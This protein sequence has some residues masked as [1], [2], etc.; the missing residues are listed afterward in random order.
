MALTDLQKV[1]NKAAQKVRDRAYNQRLREQRAALN[2]VDQDPEVIRLRQLADEANAK[3]E[4]RRKSVIA[5]RDEI[6]EQIEALQA[7]LA[8]LNYDAKLGA[9]AEARRDASNWW[10][11]AKNIKT[12]SIEMQFPDL[13]GAARFSAVAWQPPQEV[14]D[15]MEEARRT[16]TVEDAAPKKGKARKP[17]L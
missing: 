15:E 17:G 4:L 8:A 2:A 9:L 10:N 11:Q 3:E 16:A 13:Q 12:K 6:R 14:L 1:Q 5:Q 7:K